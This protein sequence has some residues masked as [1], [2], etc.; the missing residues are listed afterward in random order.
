SSLAS[1]AE[2]HRLPWLFLCGDAPEEDSGLTTAAYEAGALAVLPAGSEPE[3]VVQAVDRAAQSLTSKGP[4]KRRPVRRSYRAG[5]TIPLSVWEVLAVKEGVVAQI[6]WH[7]DGGEGLV[8]LWGPG[9][10]LTGH[11]ADACGLALRAHSDAVVD[12]VRLDALE[13]GGAASI[14]SLLA[15]VRGLEAWSSV[16]SR[17]NMQERLLGILTLLAEQFG[18]ARAQ[19]T[20]ID[21]RITHAQL[22]AAI[23][24]TRATVTRLLGPLR[25]QGLVLTVT[26]SEGERFC[27]PPRTLNAEA[28][29]PRDAAGGPLPSPRARPPSPSPTR[30]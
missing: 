24:A 19:G 14:E 7:G 3:L 25:R 20:L 12:L 1:A 23:G 13:R 4:G 11:P 26:S 6:T 29:A 2:W 28:T 18:V 8:G 10:L 17:Q 27:L 22:A 15:R 30:S 5:E 16:Q 21:V 9:H